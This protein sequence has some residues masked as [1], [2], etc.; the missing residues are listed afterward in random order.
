MLYRSVYFPLVLLN[1]CHKKSFLYT[2]IFF[3]TFSYCSSSRFSAGK[4][5]LKIITAALTVDIGE[6]ADNIKIFLLFAH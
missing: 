4:R 5:P 3:Q 2:M 6:F 1:D